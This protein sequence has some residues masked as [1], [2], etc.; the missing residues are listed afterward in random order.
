M[1]AQPGHLLIEIILQD[2]GPYAFKEQF[3]LK[4]NVK[5]F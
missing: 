2:K 3:S 5:W 1:M 4:A